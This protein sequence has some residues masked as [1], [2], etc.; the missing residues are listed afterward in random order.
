[1]S[2]KEIREMF[3]NP[4]KVFRQILFKRYVEQWVYETS[5]LWV[6]FNCLKGQEPSVSSYHKSFS[7]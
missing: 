3:G 6:Q 7:P 1:M 4:D 5:G 2:P